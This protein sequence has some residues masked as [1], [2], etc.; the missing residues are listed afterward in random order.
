[1]TGILALVR[2]GESEGNA[3][4]LFTG[5]MDVSLTDHG[6]REAV[7]AGAAMFRAGL[8][9]DIVFTSSMTRAHQ[10]SAIIMREAGRFGASEVRDP[11]L[12]ER[13][14]GALTG[15]TKAQAFEEW[16][17]DHVESWR[18]SFSGSPPEGESL[19]DTGARV[20]LFYLRAILPA[21]LEGQTVMA[22]AHGNSLRA[23]MMAIEGIDANDII[24]VEVPRC[25]PVAYQFD[26]HARVKMKEVLPLVPVHD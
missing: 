21:V 16:G 9:I 7:A 12:N 23:M 13:D 11:S 6:R 20:W 8:S 3:A 24:N 18:R 25:A 22:V 2:H 17:R 26:R 4:D 14:Y 15:L 1:M 19:R 10:T 5:R